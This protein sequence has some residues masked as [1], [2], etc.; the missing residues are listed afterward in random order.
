MSPHY[1]EDISEHTY[2]FARSKAPRKAADL[3]TIEFACGLRGNLRVLPKLAF[4]FPYSEAP[5]KL[6]PQTQM[7]RSDA[8]PASAKLINVKKPNFEN[9]ISPESNTPLTYIKSITSLCLLDFS[10]HDGPHAYQPCPCILSYSYHLR[11][12]AH[13]AT[14][15]HGALQ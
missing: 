10:P 8:S 12:R 1:S 4:S 2:V 13:P 14:S 9:G 5:V 11:L 3:L 7:S 6:P 15:D